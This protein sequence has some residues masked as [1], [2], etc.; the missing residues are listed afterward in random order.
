MKKARQMKGLSQFQLAELLKVKQNTISRWE[1]GE[2]EPPL[3]MI[4]KIAVALDCD[5]NYLH[6]FAK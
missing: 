6:G 3:E 1:G 5:P 2:R 4:N